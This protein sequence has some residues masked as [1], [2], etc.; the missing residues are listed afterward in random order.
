M[1]FDL[2][3]TPPFSSEDELDA[4]DLVQAYVSPDLLLVQSCKNSKSSFGRKTVKSDTDLTEGSEIDDS[5]ISPKPTGELLP[6][7]ILVGMLF[8]AVA[9]SQGTRYGQPEL[10]TGWR[11]G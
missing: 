7:K 8:K 10:E 1:G 11:K 9:L 4:G 5:D 6:L 2:L 3:R